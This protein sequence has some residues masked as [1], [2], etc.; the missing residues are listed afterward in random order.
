MR[1]SGQD[2]YRRANGYLRVQ[3]LNFE[4]PQ[5]NTTVSPIVWFGTHKDDPRFRVGKC[6]IAMKPHPSAELSIPRWSFLGLDAT[7]DLIPCVQ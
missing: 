7:N 5:G 6:W 3:L 4:I 1:L 2:S